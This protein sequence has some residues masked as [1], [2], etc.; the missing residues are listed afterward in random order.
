MTCWAFFVG[1]CGF[2]F[3]LE[4]FPKNVQKGGVQR[5][6][7]GIAGLVVAERERTT[8]SPNR[9][10]VKMMEAIPATMDKASLMPFAKKC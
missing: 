7:K 2:K 5:A 4:V 10:G 8:L 6:A 1:S 3:V 9:K